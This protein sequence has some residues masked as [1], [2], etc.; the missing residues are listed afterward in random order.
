MHT[1]G[2]KIS[3]IFVSVWFQKA[4]E[5]IAYITLGGERSLSTWWTQESSKPLRILGRGRPQEQ[6]QE[7]C[8]WEASWEAPAESCII[9]SVECELREQAATAT[10][11][12]AHSQDLVS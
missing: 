6:V 9:L 11:T 8:L 7:W 1:W 3:L 10:S 2:K 5:M 12:K 4:V